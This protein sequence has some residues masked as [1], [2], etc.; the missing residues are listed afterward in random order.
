MQALV[1]NRFD[2]IQEFITQLALG[3]FQHKVTPSESLDELDALIVGINMLG[4]ELKISQEKHVALFEHAG[5]AI[6]IYC[7][8]SDKFVDSNEAATALLGFSAKDLRLLTIEELFPK[9]EKKSIESKVT[10]LKSIVQTNFYTQVE[11]KAGKLKDVSFL[12]KLL[13]YGDDQFFQIS[14]RDITKSKQIS[15]RLVKQNAELNQAQ[16][17]ISELS[18][19]PSEN[20]NP[21][22]RLNEK[23]EILYNNSASSLNFLSDFKIKGN[24]LNDRVLKDQL[25]QVKANRSPKTIIETRNKRNYSLTLVYVHEF[26]YI[27]IYAADITAFINQ[28][29][30]K[31]KSLTGLKDEIENQKEFYEQILNNIPSDIAVFD[32][33]HRYLFI[34]PQGIQD[35]TTREFMIGKDDFD[36]VNFKGVSDEKAVL[37]RK[38]F[39]EILRN[40][41]PETWLDEFIDKNGTR[42]IVQRSLGPIFDEKGQLRF[43]IG[44]GTDITKRVLAEEENIKLSFVA[45]N[46]NNGVLM[47][48][49][50]REITWAN[51]AF[52]ERSG[53]SLS[54]LIHE[55]AADYLLGETNVS[56]LNEVN[57]AM[58]NQKKVSVELLRKSKT[59]KEYWVDLNVQPLFDNANNLTGFMFVEF[60][61]TDRIINKQT[62]ENINLILE[63]RVQEKTQKLRAN[64]LK[65]ENSLNKEKERTI[66][67][68]ISEKKLK[69]SIIKEKELGKLK[70]SFVTVASHQF[71]TP[72]AVIQS[73]AQLLEM[74]NKMDVKQAPEKYAKVTGRI[75][76][77]IANMTTLM[78]DVLTLGKLTSGKVPYSPEDIDLVDFCTQMVE[79]FN[80][81]QLDGR[82]IGFATAGEAYVV[83]LDA[84]L[85]NHSLSN[86]ISNA[87]KYSIGKENPELR[88]DFKPT[89][90]VLSVRDYGL[91]IPEEEHLHLF[92]PFFR[93]GNVTNIQGTGL[94]LSIAKEYVE[95]NKGSISAKSVLGEGSCFEIK[96]KKDKL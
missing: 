27:N 86:L 52:L 5:D 84:K 58:D 23:F 17:E 29:N 36:Y 30:E 54:E 8:A 18:K 45:K 73:N 57:E 44:Y 74:F 40:K 41:H 76:S 51:T 88:I 49:Q 20:P 78:D 31:E 53:Y 32:K 77:A 50:N 2:Q 79:D 28:V 22:L 91:G 72:L 9:E 80:T 62:I 68:K 60:D 10:Y 66:A 83:A 56:F 37:R 93:A 90:L 35:N 11:T 59:G 65:L 7:A 3:N 95:V 38:L 96:F 64:E 42:K 15:N 39:K 70:A 82:S 71:R 67:L 85:L 48:N 34:N 25:K 26:N 4:E 92:E 75:T 1:D 6:L 21:I 33:N 61:I 94:G 14:L 46:T 43:V 55:N 69:K 16:K 12:S 87:F 89:E 24:I 47:L 81:V 13:P 19:F 63:D